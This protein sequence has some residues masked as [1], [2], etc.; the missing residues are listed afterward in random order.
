MILKVTD[1]KNEIEGYTIIKQYKY[2]VIIIDNK[3]KIN[4]HIDIIDKK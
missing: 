4:Y 3:L 1:D 2:L